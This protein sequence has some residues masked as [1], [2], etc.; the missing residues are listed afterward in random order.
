M[1]G[2]QVFSGHRVFFWG[3]ENVLELDKG[4]GFMTLGMDKMSLNG[5]LLND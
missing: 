4:H 1:D 5:S 2:Q 3:D